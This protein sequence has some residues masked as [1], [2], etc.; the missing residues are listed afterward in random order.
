MSFSKMTKEQLNALCKAN[1]IRGYSKLKKEQIIEKLNDAGVQPAEQTNNADTNTK[2]ITKEKVARVEKL[3][4]KILKAFDTDKYNEVL[5][6]Y[7]E[8]PSQEQ[9]KKLIAED[10]KSFLDNADISDIID[11]VNKFGALTPILYQRANKNSKLS[12]KTD[13]DI[14]RILVHFIF[15]VDDKATTPLIKHILKLYAKAKK[16]APVVK[17]STVLQISAPLEDLE[18]KEEIAQYVDSDASEVDV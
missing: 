14:Y 8:E 4:K 9:I 15:D 10:L 17:K 16:P 11:Y 2:K 1:G 3:D 18:E 6:E 12:T 5:M 7:K 13:E